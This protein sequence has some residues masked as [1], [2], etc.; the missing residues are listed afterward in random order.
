M[1]AGHARTGNE[2]KVALREIWA[3]VLLADEPSDDTNFYEDGGDS[4]LAL[5]FSREIADRLGVDV[6]P[7]LFLTAERFSEI[8]TAVRESP[9]AGADQES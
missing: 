2:V 6:P 9:R 4:L 8:V 5:V 3:S 1:T 7:L